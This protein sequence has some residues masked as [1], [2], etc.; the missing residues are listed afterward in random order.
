V[1]HNR[2]CLVA[3]GAYLFGAEHAAMTDP[4]PTLVEAVATLVRT[5]SEERA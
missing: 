3:G 1:E 4:F 2:S 5:V